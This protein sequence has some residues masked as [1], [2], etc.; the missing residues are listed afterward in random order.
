MEDVEGLFFAAVHSLKFSFTSLFS[1]VLVLLLVFSVFFVP[2]NRLAS[3]RLFTSSTARDSENSPLQLQTKRTK[4]AT[5][6][7]YHPK[8]RKKQ[9]AQ[10]K[11]AAKMASILDSAFENIPVPALV[12]K[13]VNVVQ[14]TFG[15][16][17][18]V[19]IED[20]PEVVEIENVEH[21]A[22]NAGAQTQF[23][24][25]E[26][27]Q[28]VK[29]EHHEDQPLQPEEHENQPEDESKTDELNS[30]DKDESVTPNA[31]L[32][33]QVEAL[34]QFQALAAAQAEDEPEYQRWSP[35]SKPK[36]SGRS[37]L[38]SNLD[39]I[40]FPALEPFEV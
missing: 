27:V 5:G 28:P 35:F 14:N 33:A 16:S 23:V 15:K 40:P 11:R 34:A 7:R 9:K 38:D 36:S 29:P 32:Q 20:K 24:Q 18:S 4:K 13:P 37:L 19:K 3:F 21:M 2:V 30:E 12:P 6:R 8:D 31:Q 17:E 1:V 39:Y 25:P 10:K 26:P 22:V